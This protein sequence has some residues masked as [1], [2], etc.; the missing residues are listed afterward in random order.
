[1]KALIS[2]V[3]SK[4]HWRGFLALLLIGLLIISC[5]KKSNRLSGTKPDQKNI[6]QS[7][8][9]FTLQEALT[10]LKNLSAPEGANQAL[11]M[12]LKARFEK[13][14]LYR[15]MQKFIASPPQGTD[16]KV[17]DL[18]IQNNGDGTYSLVW[19]YRNLGDYDQDGLVRASDISPLALHFAHARDI[20]GNWPDTSDPAID[21]NRDGQLTAVD[22][23]GI[24]FNFASQVADYLIQGASSQTGPWYDLS[25]VTV[26]Q[27]S[28]TGVKKFT[29]N[30]GSLSYQTYRVIPRDATAT[31]GEASWDTLT[32]QTLTVPGRVDWDT[33]GPVGMA[34]VSATTEDGTST[35]Y[36]SSAPDGTFSIALAPQAFPT[37]VKIEVNIVDG[38]TGFKIT[39]AQWTDVINDPGTTPSIPVVLS[40]PAGAMLTVAGGQAQS[41]DGAILMDGVP[42]EVA[43]A[44]ARS[45]DPDVSP[46]V[47]PGDFAEQNTFRLNSSVFMWVTAQDQFGNQVFNLTSPTDVR[48]EVPQTQWKDLEDLLEG[49]DK[50]DVPIYDYD[51]TTGLWQTRAD[52]YLVDEGNSVIP[53][54][55]G[56][57]IIDGTYTGRIYAKFSADHFSFWN[58][59]YSYI[60]IWKLSCLPRAKR[61]NECVYKALRLAE[62]I[63]KSQKGRDAYA[64][65]NKPGA[66]LSKE[67]V[68]NQGPCINE[69]VLDNA[70][71]EYRGEGK[72]AGDKA[73]T[74]LFLH[75]GIWDWCGPS[76]TEA[77]RKKTILLIASTLLHE[78]A[79]W[80][81]D[82]KKGPPDT[83]G[84]EGKQFEKDVFGGDISIDYSTGELYLDKFDGNGSQVATQAEIDAFFNDATWPKAGSSIGFGKRISQTVSLT[85]TI[86]L[87][88]STYALGEQIPV[89]VEFK[90]TG[91]DPFSVMNKLILENYP[92]R[93]EILDSLGNRVAYLGPEFDLN[94]LPGDYITLNPGETQIV[95]SDLL[96]DPVTGADHYDLSMKSDYT[97]KAVFSEFFGFPATESNT[98]NFTIG[99]GGFIT[100]TVTDAGTSLPIAGASVRVKEG[101]NLI[102][103][104]TTQPDGTYTTPELPIGTY[105]VEAWKTG[106]YLNRVPNIVVTGGTTTPG[107]DLALTQTSGREWFMFGREET[108]QRRSPV[109]GPTAANLRWTYQMGGAVYEMSPS[110]APDG[111][112]YVG[113]DDTYIYAINPDSTLKW[114]YKTGGAIRSTPSVAPDGTVYVGSNDYSFYAINPDGTLLWSYATGYQMEGS[115]PAVDPDGTIYVGSRD[116]VFYAFNPDGSVKWSYTTGAQIGCSPAIGPDGTI[117]VG[118]DDTKL[119]AFNP[120]GTTKWIYQS[121]GYIYSSPA[122]AS[123]G[124]IY[125]GTWGYS[126]YALNSDGTLKWK[127]SAANYFDASPAIGVDGT[128]YCGSDD[129]TFYAI[130]PDGSLKWSFATGGTVRSSAAIGGD[131]TIY[132]GS[133]NTNLYA[134]NPDGTVLWQFQAGQGFYRT[135]PIIAGDGTLYVGSQ[136]NYLY[137]FRDK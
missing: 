42:G 60:Y 134:L 91:A 58:V 99:P 19:S 103:A 74:N 86:T 57:S 33:G 26:D 122:I 65:V 38:A 49:N 75:R 107:I 53:E 129:G 40:N 137:T 101:Y 18:K 128:V 3:G 67:F 110:L 115:G 71:G 94:L 93:F 51:Y 127:Y 48:L 69:E 55:V 120:D 121:D 13:A 32:N 72:P 124:T 135:G 92:I 27:A 66:D 5:G 44:A 4:V 64:K 2:F 130:N 114:K 73:K 61:N 34:D 8:Q 89:S 78:T 79:H 63:A 39:N 100:G 83:A 117:Y 70:N 108:H 105:S 123:D 23:S 131:G 6:P 17:A 112:I 20:N 95:T 52:G 30:I 106:Y 98:L 85:I 35:A 12:E 1:M 9:V 62:M 25:T 84:E 29:A 88:K 109:A 87:Q 50:I 118:S 16:N 24:A 28:G 43:Q 82:V 56:T 47:F 15:G 10:E 77:Q 104:T 41:A 119:Y 11:L 81:D 68:D 22:V 54:D 96:R 14:L 136:D 46:D 59:D 125:F 37:R 102:S 31:Q 126:L 36:T 45:Y 97:V 132:F 80:K 133:N 90:N 113:S 111:T 76:S 21:G 7:G 116:N